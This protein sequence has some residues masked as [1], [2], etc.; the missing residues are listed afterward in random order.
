MGWRGLEICYCAMNKIRNVFALVA[1]AVVLLIACVAASNPKVLGISVVAAD[2]GTGTNLTIFSDSVG[3]GGHVT[4]SNK[5][6]TSLIMLGLDHSAGDQNELIGF[7]FGGTM[8]FTFTISSNEFLLTGNNMVPLRVWNDQRSMSIGADFGAGQMRSLTNASGSNY[9]TGPVHVD[10]GVVPSVTV[11]ASN[12]SSAQ[13]DFT[14][15]TPVYEITNLANAIT[16]QV[17]NLKRGADRWVYIRTDGTARNIT[18]STNGLTSATRISWG[19][20]SITN[21]AT[22][23]TVTNRARLNLANLP[24]GEIAAGYEFQQ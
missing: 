19:F 4:L 6:A 7:R 3:V 10:V 8:A 13:I 2:A 1:A 21:G 22:S 11:I 9:F 14:A 15:G 24:V 17:T 18:V 20:N 12:V 16:L 23:F 5:T